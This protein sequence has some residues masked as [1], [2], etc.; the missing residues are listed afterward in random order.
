MEGERGAEPSRL[1]SRACL[2]CTEP[3][4]EASVATVSEQ[5]LSRVV[6]K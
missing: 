2:V 6:S 3:A 4:K 5:C 1:S